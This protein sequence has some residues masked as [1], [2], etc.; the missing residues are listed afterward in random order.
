M[1]VA[2]R[3]VA[4]YLALLFAAVAVVFV[5]L[6]RTDRNPAIGSDVTERVGSISRH[7]CCR[8][9]STWLG[10]DPV[11]QSP[12]RPTLQRSSPP[13]RP[14][15]AGSI[16]VD[17]GAQGMPYPLASGRSLPA[18]RFRE[19]SLSLSGYDNRDGCSTGYSQRLLNK[20]NFPHIVHKN[21]GQY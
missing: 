13:P 2:A 17:T 14:A 8:P 6:G 16:V 19:Q 10:T 12:F 20:E 11:L 9:S 4:S 1:Y 18:L 15:A 21:E 5:D 7:D 3:R